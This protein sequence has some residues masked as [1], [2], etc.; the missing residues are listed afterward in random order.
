MSIDL[1]AKTKRFLRIDSSAETE[2][3]PLI[4]LFLFNVDS[5]VTIRLE[6]FGRLLLYGL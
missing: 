5:I 6:F 4:Y 3:R 2:M 1:F